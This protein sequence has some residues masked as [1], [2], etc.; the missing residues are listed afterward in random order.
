MKIKHLIYVSKQCCEEKDID[1]L[2]IEGEKTLCS[3]QNFNI[4]IRSW[5]IIHY[6]VEENIFAVIVYTLS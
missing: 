5:M 3:Y 2:L 4:L 6:I 1:L